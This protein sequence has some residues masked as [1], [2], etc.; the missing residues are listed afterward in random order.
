MAEA[1]RDPALEHAPGS[2]GRVEPSGHVAEQRGFLLGER[3]PNGLLEVRAL[4]GVEPAAHDRAQIDGVR[5]DRAQG[6]LAE[7]G[8]V[9]IEHVEG[10]GR[11]QFQADVEAPELGREPSVLVLG[12]DDEHLV[13]GVQGA[14][15]ERGQQ[16]GLAGAGVPEHP[17]VGVRIAGFVEG[18]DEDRLPGGAARADD[19]PVLGLEVGVEPGEEGGER[20]GVE[21]AG[22]L[23]GVD[24]ER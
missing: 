23:Q 21:D 20:A 13:A 19:E 6:L 9:H 12:V 14:D 15:R 24:A 16:V 2:G 4:G 7:G 8:S 3:V 17:D 5:D 10:V 11:A 1:A 18:V 22:S